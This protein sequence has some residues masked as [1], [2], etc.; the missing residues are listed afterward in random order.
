M[1][2]VTFKEDYYGRIVCSELEQA[3]KKSNETN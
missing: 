1:I 3:K 2:R